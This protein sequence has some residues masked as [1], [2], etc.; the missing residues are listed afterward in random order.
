MFIG[1]LQG[2]VL[3][4]IDY[5]CLFCVGGEV[6]DC[7]CKRILVLF[8][9]Y[10]VV[11]RVKEVGIFIF[12]FFIFLIG[13]GEVLVDVVVCCCYFLFRFGLQ[14]IGINFVCRENLGICL[15]WYDIYLSFKKKS[16]FVFVFVYMSGFFVCR[17]CTMCDLV[18]LEVGRVCQFFWKLELMVVVG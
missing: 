7:V 17:M 16:F 18:F 8:G 11:W 6:C 1:C 12:N 13:L 10:S 2:N 4:G 15:L 9:G 5:I 14:G 3:L